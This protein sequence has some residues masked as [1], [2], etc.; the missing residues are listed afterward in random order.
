MLSDID[1]LNIT[2]N[3]ATL[4]K[5]NNLKLLAFNICMDHIHF[6]IM[7]GDRKLTSIV[8]NIKSITSRKYLNKK[9]NEPLWAQK[10]NRKLINDDDQLFTSITYVYNNRIKHN[11]PENPI[12]QN[13]ISRMVIPI[14]NIEMLLKERDEKIMLEQRNQA[15]E[16]LSKDF[17]LGKFT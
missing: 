1:E 9:D 8:Q 16:H 4:V 12:L 2:Q 3:I 14:D 15:M 10:F 13:I 5:K 7:C 11:L 17:E 6:V